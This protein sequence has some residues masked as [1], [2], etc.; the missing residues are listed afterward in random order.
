[1][2]EKGMGYTLVPELSVLEEENNLN[3]KRFKALEPV[4]E[5]SLVCHK[6]FAKER[7]IEILR[8]S[9]L[10]EIPKRFVKKMIT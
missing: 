5:V 9:I 4:R 8:D 1:M 7:L 10:K 3:V 6:S 2:V